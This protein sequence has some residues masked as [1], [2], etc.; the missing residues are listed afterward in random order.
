MN[1]GEMENRECVLNFNWT[2]H[3]TIKQVKVAKLEG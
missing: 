2:S 1:Y 3:F